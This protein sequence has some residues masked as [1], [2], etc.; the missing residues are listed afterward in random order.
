MAAVQEPAE[1]VQELGRPAQQGV[2]RGIEI[3]RSREL[4]ASVPAAAASRA[5]AEVVVRRALKRRRDLRGARTLGPRLRPFA[6][7]TSGARLVCVD[8]TGRCCRSIP[9]CRRRA[10]HRRACLRPRWRKPTSI[11]RRIWPPRPANV[12]SSSKRR[13]RKPCGSRFTRKPPRSHRD[14]R[15]CIEPLPQDWRFK[16]EAWQRWPYNLIYQGFLLQQ[17]WWHNATT[18]VRGVSRQHENVVTFAARQLLDTL[19]P[20]NFLLTNPQ[21][22]ERTIQQGGTNLLRGW[23]N[24][25]EDWYRYRVRTETGRR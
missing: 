17:Q 3:M 8:G 21:V 13:S 5:L 22:L 25:L 6:T 11:G 7:R 16:D 23:Q 12:F 10:L 15:R 24:F 14:A 1:R 2:S 4:V 19:S 9:Q 20:S 18:G